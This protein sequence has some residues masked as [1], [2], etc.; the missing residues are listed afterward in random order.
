MYLHARTFF[1]SRWYHFYTHGCGVFACKN[2]LYTCSYIF[3]SHGCNVFI[4]ARTFFTLADT[5]LYP[6][7]A[8]IFT[9]ITEVLPSA[10]WAMVTINLTLLI[11]VVL[12]KLVLIESLLT[13]LMF[14]LPML[15]NRYSHHY[16]T[17]LVIY[18]KYIYYKQKQHVSV[19]IYI[20]INVTNISNMYHIANITIKIY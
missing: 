9:V 12:I 15:A 6:S 3:Y 5:I 19:I 4:H 20:K 2:V 11:E 18:N 13:N 14:Y 8:P 16:S 1:Y 10:N 7:L 17:M